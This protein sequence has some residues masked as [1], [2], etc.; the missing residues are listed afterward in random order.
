MTVA[1]RKR[2]VE[3]ASAGAEMGFRS[4]A[5]VL[6]QALRESGRSMRAV[7]LEADVDSSLVSKYRRGVVG[8]GGD[9]AA[10]LGA[11]LGVPSPAL[12]HGDAWQKVTGVAA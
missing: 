6:D 7:C 10:R 11:V 1:K 3:G 5:Q 2:D 4:G 9:N 8:I 12:Q